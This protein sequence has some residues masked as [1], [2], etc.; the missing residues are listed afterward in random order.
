MKKLKQ[1]LNDIILISKLTK[2]T[3]KKL[4]LLLSIVLS[5]LTVFA[6]ILIILVFA[7]LLSTQNSESSGYYIFISVIVENL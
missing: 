3:K 6:D 1:L 4:R 2:V 7:N 5:N